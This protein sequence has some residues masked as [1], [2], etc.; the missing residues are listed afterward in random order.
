M[1]VTGF[2]MGPFQLMDLIGIDINLSVTQSLH[3]A[4][5]NVKRFEPSPMQ[6]DKVK[7]GEL[8]KKSGKG[9]YNYDL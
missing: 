8:G 3:D 7:Q 9:F 1:Q 6:L 4:L 5:N 2:K